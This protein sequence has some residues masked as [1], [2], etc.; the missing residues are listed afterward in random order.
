MSRTRSSVDDE[1]A[2]SSRPK[3]S[4]PPVTRKT[5]AMSKGLKRAGKVADYDL[6]PS[7]YEDEKPKRTQDEALPTRRPSLSTAPTVTP[8]LGLAAPPPPDRSAVNDVGASNANRPEDPR[9]AR[10]NNFLKKADSAR[11]L[12]AKASVQASESVNKG[13]GLP[14]IGNLPGVGNIGGKLF[15]RNQREEN[16][17][18]PPQPPETKESAADLAASALKGLYN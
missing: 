16:Q 10:V 12:T 9:D 7:K 13:L 17:N 15:K 5:K 6:A 18:G 2:G 1:G 4:G 11:V 14:G 3:R 8:V